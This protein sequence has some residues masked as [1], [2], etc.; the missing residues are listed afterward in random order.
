MA[1]SGVLPAMW[2]MRGLGLLFLLLGGAML[3]V[4]LGGFADHWLAANVSCGDSYTQHQCAPAEAQGVLT[5]VG[6]IFSGVALMLLAGSIWIGRVERGA[7]VFRDQAIQA[8]RLAPPSWSTAT[9]QPA[10]VASLS[11]GD[12]LVDK[13]DRLAA[14]RDRGVLSAD[15]FEAQK[16]KLLSRA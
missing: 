4:G 12:Q 5:L 14:L 16:A 1:R 10:A 2:I 15:E 6:A 7:R 8:A 9:V 3:V 11:A 13:L